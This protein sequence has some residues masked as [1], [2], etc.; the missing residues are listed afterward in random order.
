M[1]ISCRYTYLEEREGGVERVRGEG[2]Q[3]GERVEEGE[4]E[5]G[6]G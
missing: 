5:R 1:S 4:G 6:G 2:E 3:M